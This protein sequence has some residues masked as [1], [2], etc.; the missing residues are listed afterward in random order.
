MG[1]EL[2]PSGEVVGRTWL[3]NAGIAD[4]ELSGRHLRFFHT[5]G[6]VQIED[7][8]SR[9][10]TFVNGHRISPDKPA[11]LKDGTI[12]RAG[13]TILVY[14]DKFEGSLVPEKPLGPLVGPFGLRDVQRAIDRLCQYPERNVLLEG[15]TGTGKEL[16]AEAVIHALGRGKKPFGKSNVTSVAASVF[17]SQFF[18]WAKGAY[19]GSGEGGRGILREHDGGAVFLDEIGELPLELQPKLL[20]LLEN[21]EVQPV[22]V[23]KS[24]RVDVA[25][26]AATNR[27]LDEM[28]EKGRFRRDLLAR[29]YARIELPPLRARREDIFSIAAALRER[30]KTPFEVSRIEVEA[31]E[32]L[33]LQPW[34]ANIRDLDR[35]LAISDPDAPLTLH[36]VQRALGPTAAISAPPPISHETAQRMLDACQGNQSEAARRLGIERAKLRRLLKL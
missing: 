17:E 25:I 24:L 15:E 36:A 20:R 28:V 35:V 14:R 6:Q 18:G 21:G 4:K 11:E 9:N 5:R 22:G 12:I 1:L 16:L 32:L 23:P 29:F 10:G 33:M 26:V 30:R 31:M 13:K 19:S 3:A 8:A 7:M 2:P 27:D 34:P